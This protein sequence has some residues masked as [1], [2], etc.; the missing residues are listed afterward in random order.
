[1][2]EISSASHEQSEGIDQVNLAVS[3]MD[4][5]VQQNAALV[6]QAAAAAAALQDQAARLT[7]VVAAF[8][9]NS[10]DVI[11]LPPVELAH[12]PVYKASLSMHPQATGS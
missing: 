9:I 6:E 11:D 4:T 2:E 10:G 8:R 12:A 3:Q 7:D 1:M 5:V